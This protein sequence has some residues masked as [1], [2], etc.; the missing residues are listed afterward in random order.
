[1]FG[2]SLS[3]TLMVQGSSFSEKLYFFLLNGGYLGTLAN[4]I[5]LRKNKGDHY[6]K[7]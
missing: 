1:M 6:V 2:F 5:I 4:R 7:G 3:N